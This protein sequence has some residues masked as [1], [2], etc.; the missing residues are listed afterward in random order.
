MVCPLLLFKNTISQA[1]W[2]D[3]QH[4]WRLYL[5][6]ILFSIVWHIVAIIPQ[7]LQVRFSYSM[8]IPIHLGGV[9]YREYPDILQSVL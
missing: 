9:I 6:V 4:K 5:L 1:I 2:Q 3:K 8:K 7:G